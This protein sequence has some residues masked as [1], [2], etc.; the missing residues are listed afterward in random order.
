MP[1][2]RILIGG[3]FPSGKYKNLDIKKKGSDISGTGA[4]ELLFAAILAKQYFLS[5]KH[6][7]KAN[8]NLIYNFLSAVDV[9]GLNAYGETKGRIKPG[10]HATVNL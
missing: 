2:S 1:D 10:S 4:Y 8:L 3:S 5:S 7:F 9:S 6:P